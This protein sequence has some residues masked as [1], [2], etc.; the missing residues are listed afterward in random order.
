MQKHKATAAY[1]QSPFGLSFIDYV[2]NIMSCFQIQPSVLSIISWLLS[3]NLAIA[4]V[5]RG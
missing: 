4:S 1:R 2:R 3:T 5:E